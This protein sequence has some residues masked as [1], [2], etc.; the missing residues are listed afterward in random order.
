ASCAMARGKTTPMAIQKINE[1][2]QNAIKP[3]TS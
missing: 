1:T 2:L 3:A